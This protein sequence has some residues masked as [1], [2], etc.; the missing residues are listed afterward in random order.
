MTAGGPAVAGA[1]DVELVVLLDELRRPCGS[2]PKAT[3]HGYRT[4]LHLAFSCYLFDARGRFLVT[5]RAVRKRTWPGVWT[6]SACG[7]PAPGEDL[8]E[9]V[10]RRTRQE[11]GLDVQALRCAL[12]HFAYTAT[13]ASGTVENEVC[14]VFVGRVDADPRPDADEVE[15]WRWVPWE[16]VVTAAREAPWTLSPWAAEQ[17]RELA[18]GPLR[19]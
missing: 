19:P 11:L 18:D 15:E 13:D 12:P 9:A 10:R 17:V 16:A 1:H 4:P 2:A 8:A 3:V 7:H 6:N 5:R 14:P